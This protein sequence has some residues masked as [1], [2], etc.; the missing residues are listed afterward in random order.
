[1]ARVGRRAS[2]AGARAGEL[3]DRG[4]AQGTSGSQASRVSRERYQACEAPQCGQATVVETDAA[5]TNPQAH[6]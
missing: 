1:V 4:P 2:V 6:V 5:N 3:S